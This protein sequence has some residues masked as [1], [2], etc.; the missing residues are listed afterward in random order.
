VTT[1]TQLKANEGSARL[2]GNHVLSSTVSRP[3]PGRIPAVPL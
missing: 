3:Y 2:T 1:K